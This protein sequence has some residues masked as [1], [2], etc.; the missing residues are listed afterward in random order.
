MHKMVGIWRLFCRNP[1]KKCY[2]WKQ[3]RPPI[4]SK[5]NIFMS[6]QLASNS[7]CTYQ[8]KSPP[9]LSPQP[10]KGG[11]LDKRTRENELMF[12]PPGQYFHSNVLAFPR[13]LVKV[14]NNFIKDVIVSEWKSKWVRGLHGLLLWF[15]WWPR[16][17]ALGLDFWSDKRILKRCTSYLWY[18][19]FQKNSF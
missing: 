18:Q 3:N 12:L 8:S 5:L 4:S 14:F 17:I 13:L 2:S 15:W 7:F 10:E 16:M 19:R 9:L 6:G 11:D 1:D